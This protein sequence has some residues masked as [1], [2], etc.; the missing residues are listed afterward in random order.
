MQNEISQATVQ[1]ALSR[2]IGIALAVHGRE[3]VYEITGVQDDPALLRQ[4][5]HVIEA[6]RRDGA[7]VCGT[8]TS[9][10]FMAETPEELNQTCEFLHDRA[11]TTLSQVAAMKNVSLPDLR[12]QLKLPT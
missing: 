9:G 8:P 7:H 11:M 5:R 1:Q 2:H 4:L 10:Y 6:L 3:L 12:G